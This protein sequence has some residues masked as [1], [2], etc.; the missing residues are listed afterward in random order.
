MVRSRYPYLM[1]QRR[2]WFVRM[3]V[4]VELRDIMGQAIF[5][6]PTGHAD[7]HLAATAAAPI[8]A[9]LQARIRDS[10]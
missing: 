4:P 10:P 2:R 5:K 1:Q 9:E 6:V 7:P 3:V 8:I